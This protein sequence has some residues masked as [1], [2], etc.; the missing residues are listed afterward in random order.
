VNFTPSQLAAVNTGEPGDTCVVAVPGS[1]KTT[2]LVEYYRRLV[3]EKGVS[4]QRILAITFTEKAARHMKD[5]LAS[6]LQQS[7]ELRRE[8][9]QANV[10]TIHGFCT[11]LL[12]ENSIAAGLDPEFQV[13]DARRATILQARAVR[14][15]LDEQFAQ[16]PEAM[17]RMIQGLAS[18]DIAKVIPEI[19]DTMRAAG[20]EPSH[21]RSIRMAEPPLAKVRRAVAEIGHENTFNWKPQQAA[22]LREALDA[23]R[24]IAALADA[25][26]TIEH[27]RLPPT[28]PTWGALNRARAAQS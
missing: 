24:D 1:G 25:P 2:V 27:F 10:S 28:C 7:P 14:E 11:R 20:L 19:Y 9:E 4:P 15:A 3:T 26:V 5:K 8:L 16:K 22:R 21:L 13:L 23:A 18:P 17:R 12:R 6:S